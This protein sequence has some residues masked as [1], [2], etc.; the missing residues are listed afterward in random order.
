M[1]WVSFT[2]KWST[3]LIHSFCYSC[4]AE[5]TIDYMNKI[6]IQLIMCCLFLC[7]MYLAFI[8]LLAHSKFLIL[9][10]CCFSLMFFC[11]ARKK[12]FWRCLEMTDFQTLRSQNFF[13]FC[14]TEEIKSRGLIDY[15][16]MF[17]LC[18]LLPLS[19]INYS[20]LIVFD[21]QIIRKV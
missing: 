19:S 1:L 11:G 7:F 9:W 5:W 13:F 16:R 12:I 17:I 6:I 4:A 14:S 10:S 2:V 3:C 15:D 20:I 18:S 8:E 21:T